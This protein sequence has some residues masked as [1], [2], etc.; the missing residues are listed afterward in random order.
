MEVTNALE[1]GDAT[2]TWFPRPGTGGTVGSLA[3]RLG[4]LADPSSTSQ[5]YGLLAAYAWECLRS[6]LPCWDVDRLKIWAGTYGP[7]GGFNGTVR[8]PCE[9]S[10]Y[11]LLLSSASEASSPHSSLIRGLLDAIARSPNL[12]DAIYAALTDI[13][14]APESRTAEPLWL[15]RLQKIESVMGLTRSQL[16]Q[17]LLVERATLYQWF[18][19]AQPRPRTLARIDELSRVA[20]AWQAAGLGSARGLWYLR[21]PQGQRSLGELLSADSL[22]LAQL[23]ALI[24]M[25]GRDSKRLEIV[26][27]AGIEGFPAEDAAEAR[28]RV[29]DLFPPTF[30]E[31]E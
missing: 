16:A 28:R 10:A 5:G 4:P 25:M 19:G 22:D 20:R 3:A 9:A 8:V 2:L 24:R 7:G 18:R 14:A 12:Q 30:S 31:R 11:F 1:T 17:A 27:P 21:P 29:H 13:A 23:H 15:E 6:F 26:Q